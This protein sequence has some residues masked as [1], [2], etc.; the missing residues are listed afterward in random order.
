MSNEDKQLLLTD[1]YGRLP[2]KVKCDIIDL[3]AENDNLN[4]TPLCTYYLL[5]FENGNA[6]VKPYLRPMSSMTKEEKN[7]FHKLV[8]MFNEYELFYYHSQI[9]HRNEYE[10]LFISI[11]KLLDWLNAHHFDW[12]G[13]IEMGLALKAPE[14]MYNN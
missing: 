10:H 3:C 12:R 5:E 8:I 1:L 7:A 9:L 14:G 4:K 13:L 2:Y 11:S 6:E